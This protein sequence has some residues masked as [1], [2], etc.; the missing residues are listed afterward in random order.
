M[1][2]VSMTPDK[3]LLQWLGEIP[4]WQ[5]EALARH[6]IFMTSSD[7]GDFA[8][9]G[10]EA[11]R[12]FEASLIKAEFPL[13]RVA[14]VLTARTLFTFVL[15]FSAPGTFPVAHPGGDCGAPFPFDSA[16]FLRSCQRWQNLCQSG[17]SDGAL[18]EWL[19]SLQE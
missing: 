6:F 17:L 10:A 14:Y 4:L 2:A 1:D 18:Q 9:D 19:I 3:L 15:Q 8:F 13:R 5:R 7:S 12:H 16:Q 11:L